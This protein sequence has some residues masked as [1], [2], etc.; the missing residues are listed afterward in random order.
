MDIDPKPHIQ[1]HGSVAAAPA[2]NTIAVKMETA[3]Q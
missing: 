2:S 1:A 3:I